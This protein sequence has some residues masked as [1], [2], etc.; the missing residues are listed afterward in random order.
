MQ[1]MPFLYF[2]VAGA[3]RMV[4]LTVFGTPR[5][6]T[7]TAR[8]FRNVVDRSSRGDRCDARPD[9]QQPICDRTAG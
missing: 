7:Q 1:H 9:R 4:S 8:R 2:C 5:G 3:N 6:V